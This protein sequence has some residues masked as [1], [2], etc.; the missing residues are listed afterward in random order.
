MNKSAP[1]RR[2]RRPGR[3][4]TRQTILE[5]ARRRFLA[6][7]YA[8][9]TM[10]SVAAEAGVD[11]ALVSYFFGSKQG[12]VGAALALSVNPAEVLAGSLP[13]D[14]ET[15]PERVLTALLATWDDPALGGPLRMM[16]RTAAHD[17]DVSR[18]VRGVIEAGI[19]GQLADRLRGPDARARAGVFTA[20]L[21]GVVFTRYV[22]EL[23]PMAS[24][25]ADELVRRLAPALRLSL[26]SRAAA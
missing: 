10:R 18:L 15:L 14:L 2:G 25:P 21:A 4:D 26:R 20:Q 5:V 1:R 24:L 19:V 7:G 22:L 3:P 11:A 13:G 16:A 9:V 17:P 6:D 23:E 8:A 12:L